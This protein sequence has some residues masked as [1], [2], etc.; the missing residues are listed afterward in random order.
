MT[1]ILANLRPKLHPFDLP[2]EEC[3]LLGYIKTEGITVDPARIISDMIWV[4]VQKGGKKQGLAFP[5][6]IT[7]LCEEAGIPVVRS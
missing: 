6:L 1:F 4:N 3:H 5:S 2:L 7:C